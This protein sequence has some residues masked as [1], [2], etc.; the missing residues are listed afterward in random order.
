MTTSA[1]PRASDTAAAADADSTFP[2]AV[3]FDVEEVITHPGVAAADS[4]LQ[5][6]APGLTLASLTATRRTPAL[7][8]AWEAYSV[9][10]MSPDAYWDAVL[11]AAGIPDSPEAVTA[12][13]AVMAATWWGVVDETVL[14]LARRLAARG[15]PLAL[16]S[17]SAPDHEAAI[18]RF[19]DLFA[20]R[21]F[22]HRTGRRKPDRAAYVAVAA[23]LAVAPNG[24]LFI[25]DKQ[26]NVDAAEAAGM[27]A[28]LFRGAAALA[29]YLA[30]RR[31][32]PEETAAPAPIP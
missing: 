6:I 5:E 10:Q 24:C 7:V 13:R 31:L 2:T 20:V 19:A 3:V 25:D 21:H 12:V 26:R 11:T 32:L 1:P 8:P 16:L 28:V 30:A 22:S 4:G 15:V 14:D 17:N 23:D 9:G 18:G 27:Q 29:T